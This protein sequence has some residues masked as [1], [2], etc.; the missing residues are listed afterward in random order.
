MRA[1]RHTPEMGEI[2]GFGGDYEETCQ[3]MLSAGVQWLAPREATITVR[4]Y[5]GV[6]GI[7][8][9]EGNDTEEL[10]RV[11]IA[12]GEGCSGAQHHAVMSRLA[13]I[14]RYGWVAYVEALETALRAP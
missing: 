9:L 13:W 1:Y 14:A 2:S 8:K 12:A 7:V 11:V 3:R 6:T 10:S 5:E 4:E